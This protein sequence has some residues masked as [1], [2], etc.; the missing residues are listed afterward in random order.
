MHLM[1]TTTMTMVAA[2]LALVACGGGKGSKEP[3]ANASGGGDEPLAARPAG[4]RDGALWSC[5]IGDYDPQP[6]KVAQD[7]G[8]WRLSKLL[9]SQRFTGVVAPQGAAL[10]FAGEFF[11]PWGD[12]TSE[13]SVEFNPDGAGYVTN[14]GGD[15]IRLRYDA[16]LAS[17][18]GAAGYG[19]LTGREQ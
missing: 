9:G 14:F 3:V 16:D 8:Q 7:G 13:M 15:D 2:A 1:P 10:A 12:C 6:C 18:Y 17:E 19:G 11:C 4:F 5:Q